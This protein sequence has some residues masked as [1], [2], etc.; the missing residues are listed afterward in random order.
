M[1]FRTLLMSVMLCSAVGCATRSETYSV[2][3]KNQTTTPLTIGFTKEGPPYQDQWMA[4]E[5]IAVDRM[6]KPELYSWGILLEPVKTATTKDDMTA[7]LQ[8]DTL[9]YLRVYRGH[10]NLLQILAISSGS[11]SRVDLPLMPG[12]NSVVIIERDGKLAAIKGP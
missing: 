5:D 4:P 8:G 3:V 10:L 11:S 6:V 9:A 2:S 1:K 12:N 7:K